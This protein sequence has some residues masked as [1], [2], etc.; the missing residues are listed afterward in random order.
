M[1]PAELRIK[2]FIQP[3]QFPYETKTGWVYDSGDYEPTIRM[4]MEMASYDELRKEQAEKRERG[5]LM[6]I[7]LSFLTEAVG[8]G[9]ARTW[10]SLGS[11]WPTAASFASTQPARPSY[12]F[13]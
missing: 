2:N 5:E 4:V 8:A 11:A 7:G 12:A 1:D 13:R 10:T 9:P 3:E 6:G